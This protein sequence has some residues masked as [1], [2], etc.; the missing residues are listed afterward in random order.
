MSE[1]ETVSTVMVTETNVYNSKLSICTWW[2]LLIVAILV[3]YRGTGSDR[4]L[5]PFI[6]TLAL[7]QLIIFGIQSGVNPVTGGRIIQCLFW[8]QVLVLSVSVYIFTKSLSAGILSLIFVG[9]FAFACI[10]GIGSSS[11]SLVGQLHNW[12]FLYLYGIVASLLILLSYSKWNNV[13]LYILLVY[14]IIGA[15]VV[16]ISDGISSTYVAVGFSFA[17]WMIGYISTTK[18]SFI[19]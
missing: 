6:F 8:L 18:L 11:T 7:M 13:G 15:C 16:A 3:W 17:V 1:P 2:I 10:S 12:S 5:A 14:V 19:S 4:A 9:V